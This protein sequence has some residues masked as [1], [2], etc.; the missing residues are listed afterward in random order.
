MQTLNMVEE[1]A[2]AQNV[3]KP[4]SREYIDIEEKPGIACCLDWNVVVVVVHMYGDGPPSTW[5][6]YLKIASPNLVDRI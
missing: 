3:F 4:E 2:S 1:K 6:E 5:I